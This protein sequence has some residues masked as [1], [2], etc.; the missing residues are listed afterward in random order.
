MIERDKVAAI[1]RSQLTQ[2]TEEV[3][4]RLTD[5][6]VRDT[7][8]KLHSLIRQAVAHERETAIVKK[9]IDRQAPPS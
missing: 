2:A 6:I 3:I 4:N 1:I 9:K 8:Y 7:E 5:D